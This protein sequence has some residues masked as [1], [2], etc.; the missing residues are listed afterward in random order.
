MSVQSWRPK[1]LE[2]GKPGSAASVRAIYGRCWIRS[3]PFCNFVAQ[4]A[5]AAEIRRFGRWE[6][7]LPGQA[8][9]RIGGSRRRLPASPPLSPLDMAGR[10]AA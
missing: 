6:A 5:K 2:P 8:M 3:T 9:V 7:L 10:L 4:G 1:R